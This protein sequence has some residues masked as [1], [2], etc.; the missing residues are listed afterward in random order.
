MANE[1]IL[2]F[3]HKAMNCIQGNHKLNSRHAKKV[4]YLQSFHFMI[5]HKSRK[6]NRGADALL[7]TYL[8]LF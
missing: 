4:E 5:K 3:D 8:L 2:H 7:R 6:L 1:F